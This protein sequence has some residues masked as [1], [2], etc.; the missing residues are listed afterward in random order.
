[1]ATSIWPKG[2]TDE[3]QNAEVKAMT[4][5]IGEAAY[6]ALVRLNWQYGVGEPANITFD[7]ATGVGVVSLY[8]LHG[9]TSR[10]FRIHG[11]TVYYRGHQ[12]RF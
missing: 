1:M 5:Q 7:K 6:K 2:M 3:Q 11:S 4:D 12:S 8:V 9:T 10:A